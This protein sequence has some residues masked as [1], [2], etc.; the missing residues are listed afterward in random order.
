[1]NKFKYIILSMLVFLVFNCK[2]SRT[3]SGGEANF[4]LSSKQL[5]K[6][7]AKQTPVFKTLQ[8]KLKITYNQ[9]GNEQSYTVNFRGRGM[10]Y[11]GLV[12]RFR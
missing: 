10:K 5:L 9:D 11:Y 1:M 2:S 8:S 7:N 12:L 4:K 6:E 3:I